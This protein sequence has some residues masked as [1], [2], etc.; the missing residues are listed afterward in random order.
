MV[1]TFLTVK[2]DEKYMREYTLRAK[3]P[4]INI[5]IA[6]PY[7]ISEDSLYNMINGSERIGLTP[8]SDVLGW[9]MFYED[10]DYFLTM[11]VKEY[12]SDLSYIEVTIKL[13]HDQ[14]SDMLFAIYE[15]NFTFKEMELGDDVFLSAFKNVMKR[16]NI[17][18]E[19]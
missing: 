3:F 12:N 14:T 15:L 16:L 19:S 6:N 8:D 11:H 17:K 9:A 7:S 10:G 13:P 5:Y 18:Y 4:G 1:D 2:F